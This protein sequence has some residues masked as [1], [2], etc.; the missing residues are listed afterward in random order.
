MK[1]K[2]TFEDM[3]DK[4]LE[5]IRKEVA[6]SIAALA[7]YFETVK[8]IPFDYLMSWIGRDFPKDI[9]KV[10][11]HFKIRNSYPNLFKS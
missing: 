1:K 10:H 6:D 5:G 4:S 9:D 11:L 8:G 7:F 3:P 2:Y